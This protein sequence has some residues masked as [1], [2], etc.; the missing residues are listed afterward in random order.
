MIDG[1]LENGVAKN[2]S[3]GM[4]A[5]LHQDLNLPVLFLFS[6]FTVRFPNYR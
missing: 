3:I 1:F 5:L 4:M 6:L 2:E